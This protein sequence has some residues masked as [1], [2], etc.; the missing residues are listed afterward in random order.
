MTGSLSLIADFKSPFASY[1]FDGTI[2]FNPGQLAYQLSKAWECVAANCPAEAVGP[3][4]TIG[5]FNY[6]PDIC[7]IFTA[8][9]II[10][11]I[12]TN[13]KLK[14]INSI[15]GLLP[16]IAEPTPIPKKPN[17]EIGVSITL[18]APNSSSIPLEAL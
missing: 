18:S 7:R 9:F 17:S 5:I 12:P 11:S 14:V 4:N 6:P 16:F 15:I 10:W 2:T 13:A 3:L 1:G 8:L